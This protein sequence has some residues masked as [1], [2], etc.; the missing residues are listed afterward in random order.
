MDHCTQAGLQVFNVAVA[1]AIH[2]ILKNQKLDSKRNTDNKVSETHDQRMNAVQHNSNAFLLSENKW[3]QTKKR[4]AEY[5]CNRLKEFKEEHAQ[6]TGLRQHRE[7]QEIMV[8]WA[9]AEKA[10]KQWAVHCTIV[11]NIGA[12]TQSK[13][14][15][16]SS[17]VQKHLSNLRRERFYLHRRQHEII[18]RVWNA[19]ESRKQSLPADEIVG[20][21][22]L[23]KPNATECS[24]RELL[25]DLYCELTK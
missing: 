8:Q 25:L 21:P 23:K 19:S 20:A 18:N 3:K 17:I 24:T 13:Q 4:W 22:C 15:L 16:Q 2:R 11:D 1:F 7:R 5:N 12:L 14:D 6:I 9:T 10:Q